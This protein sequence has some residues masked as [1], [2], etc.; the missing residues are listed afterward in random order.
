MPGSPAPVVCDA[1]EHGTV[2][3]SRRT[4]VDGDETRTFGRT[5]QLM[6]MLFSG[7]VSNVVA[8][9]GGVLRSNLVSFS[10]ASVFTGLVK[11]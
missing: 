2:G 4:V 3:A 10:Y 6:Y 1:A 9:D 8:K 5:V 7:A 11:F